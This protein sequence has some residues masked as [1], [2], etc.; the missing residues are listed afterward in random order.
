MLA[1]WQ[2]DTATRVATNAAARAEGW[3]RILLR[4]VKQAGDEFEYAEPPAKTD[5][6]DWMELRATVR[7]LRHQEEVKATF[8]YPTKWNGRVVLWLD[9]RS[10]ASEEVERVVRN[11]SAVVLST[12][13]AP[14]A[15]RNPVV[16]NP[17]EAPSYTYGYNST[18]F[19]RRAHDALTLLRFCQ[20][21]DQYPAKAVDLAGFGAQAPLAA[22][23]R[24]LA[25]D[26]LDRVVL[27]PAGF[28][29]KALTDWR[30]PLFLPGA[31]R[32][33]DLDGLLSLP[34][35]PWAR[36]EPAGAVGHLRP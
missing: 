31:C 27:D 19:A 11:G 6:R 32:Y 25:G 17:R 4:D 26:A 8:L 23:V 10:D 22:A 1:A 14:E 15:E 36:L 30:D 33:G 3:R 18:L 35:A 9:G 20:T 29:W 34:G 16:K 2:A 28:T 7:N 13:F 5:R 21:R 12:L 24:F